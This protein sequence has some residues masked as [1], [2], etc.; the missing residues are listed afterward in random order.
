MSESPVSELSRTGSNRPQPRRSR[1]NLVV[2]VVC[3]ALLLTS[4]LMLT[5]EYHIRI[6]TLVCIFA[7]A[8]TG[9][10]LLGGFA[11]QV[12]LGHAVFFGIGAYAVV[13]F[14]GTY[15]WSP[16][17]AMPAGVVVSVVVA[18]LIG[19]PTFQLSGHYFA[20]ATL[21][22]LQIFHILALF[23]DPLTGGS[24][25]ISLPILDGFWALQFA[26]PEPYFYIAAGLLIAAL[27]AA[28]TVQRS[29]LGLRLNAIRLN[30]QAA[31][32]AGINLFATK[33]Q[34]LVVSAIIVS[35]AGSLYACVLQFLDPDTAFNW[36]TSNNLALFAIVGGVNFWWGPAIG[37]ALLF[38]LSEIASI[39]LTGQLAALGQLA[40]GVVLVAL[41][42]VQ[43]RGVGWW[44]HRVWRRV[45]GGSG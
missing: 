13:I 10:N 20:L 33:M 9:W 29:R 14:Q 8:A 24:S 41:I 12:S 34:A 36:N 28:R 5:N 32:L 37:A 17:L 43:P 1:L 23:W 18:L 45:T 2:P 40:Y 22:L 25:G 6:L 27:V 30:P 7:A 16:W 26:E 21:A 19:W 42:L 15:G 3:L 11:N 39:V 35:L 44:L 4:P 31:Q 38:P